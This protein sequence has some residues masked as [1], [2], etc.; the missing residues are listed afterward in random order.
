MLTVIGIDA[1][2]KAERTAEAILARTRGI[3]RH[4]N[5]G[6]YRATDIEILGAEAGYGP[7]SRARGAREVVMKLGV[8]HENPTAL[9]IFAR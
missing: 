9:G 3:F 4:L 1:A 5:L 6:D 7:H 2:R 8:E